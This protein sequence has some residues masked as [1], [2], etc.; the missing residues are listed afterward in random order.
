MANEISIEILEK[1]RTSVKISISSEPV[2]ND[3]IAS[4]KVCSRY[5]T[6][7]HDANEVIYE[8]AVDI[9]AGEGLEW[10]HEI[11]GLGAGEVYYVFC[12]IDSWSSGEVDFT[13][14]SG[15]GVFLINKTAK[16]AEIEI[17]GPP[18]GTVENVDFKVY[19]KDDASI[20]PYYASIPLE[21]GN[22]LWWRG[23]IDGLT[24]NTEYEAVVDYDDGYTR[25][26]TTFKTYSD[27]QIGDTNLKVTISNIESRTVDFVV[28]N[29]GDSSV[30]NVRFEIYL[31][32]PQNITLFQDYTTLTIPAN[33]S[34]TF[35]FLNLISDM[36]YV[37]K[38]PDLDKSFEMEFVTNEISGCFLTNDTGATT[39]SSIRVVASNKIGLN[40]YDDYGWQIFSIQTSERQSS[41][42]DHSESCVFNGLKSNTTYLVVRYWTN[43]SYSGAEITYQIGI[44]VTTLPSEDFQ[45]TYAGM[46]KNAD[47]TY[48]PVLGENKDASLF[49][50]VTA[51]EWNEYVTKLCEVKDQDGAGAGAEILPELLVEK[52]DVF[53]A[54][55]YNNMLG[56]L[57]YVD[58]IS[59][60]GVPEDQQ[61]HPGDNITAQRLND[62]KN[63]LNEHIN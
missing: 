12:D 63:R 1:G 56:V 39:S 59:I 27:G 2:G 9:S 25:Y 5:T 15:F 22:E 44:Y 41:N 58:G 28:E 46:K 42:E 40:D 14:E 34:K 23:T 13:M 37:L 16:T 48:E 30:K 11:D 51:D 61:V 7:E 55:L 26:S 3:T 18:S 4:I 19:K 60:E 62:I 20:S 45:W 32:A 33:S 31:K 52:D 50:Y 17:Y 35:S 49:F 24:P 54:K 43:V 6:E 8:E 53:T 57:C 10:I 47:G 38:V 36:G 21:S 29:S